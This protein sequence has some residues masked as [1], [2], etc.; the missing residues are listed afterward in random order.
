MQ[1]GSTLLHPAVSVCVAWVGCT[2]LMDY[3]KPLAYQRHIHS[4]LSANARQRAREVA[5]V[6][7]PPVLQRT[8][9]L[10]FLEGEPGLD[11]VVGL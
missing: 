2:L 10:S 5:S 4:R 11:L 3:T 7:I 6:R 1:K 8:V 9:P